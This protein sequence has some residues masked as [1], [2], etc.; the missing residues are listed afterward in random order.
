MKISLS[1]SKSSLLASGQ[2]SQHFSPDGKILDRLRTKLS[3]SLLQA[4]VTRTQGTFI[5]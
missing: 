1:Q 4:S 5:C 2:C 3:S